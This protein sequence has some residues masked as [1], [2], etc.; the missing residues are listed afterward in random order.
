MK[1][2][3]LHTNVKTSEPRE[4]SYGTKFFHKCRDCGATRVV[5]LDDLRAEEGP[6]NGDGRVIE[7]VAP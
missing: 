4:L 1:V 6:W 5:L 7:V 3:C 2:R